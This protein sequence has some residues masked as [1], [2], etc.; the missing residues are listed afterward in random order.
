MKIMAT[1]MTLDELD[2]AD[3]RGGFKGRDG[4]SLTRLF[5]YCHPFGLHSATTNR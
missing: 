3:T 1:W 4:Q 2:G 5:K